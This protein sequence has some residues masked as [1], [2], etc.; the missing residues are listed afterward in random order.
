MRDL[1]KILSRFDCWEDP[2]RGKG[3]HT[4]FFR[5]IDGSVF[6]YPVPTSS[7]DV[8]SVYVTGIRKRFNL[9]PRDGVTDQQF[10]DD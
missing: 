9:A 8:C 2:S 4:V 6:S 1:R 7:H 10:Y 5:E 3:S